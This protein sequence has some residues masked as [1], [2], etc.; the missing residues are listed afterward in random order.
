MRP[1]IPSRTG[2]TRRSLRVKSATQRR[3]VVGGSFVAF[4][5]DTGP[6]RHSISAKRAKGLVFQVGGRTIFTKKVNH[7]G[8]RGRPFRARAAHESLRR[9]PMAQTIIKQWNEAA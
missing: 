3:A 9:N 4:F 1:Q 8:Y 2:K 7:P 6:V 5:I